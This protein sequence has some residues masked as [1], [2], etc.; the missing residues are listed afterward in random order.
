MKVIDHE[1]YLWFFFERNDSFF[2]DVNCNHSFAGYFF[3]IELLPEELTNYKSEGHNYL[4]K[5]ANDIQFT[6][7][8]VK[9]SKSTYKDRDVSSQYIEESLSAIKLWRKTFK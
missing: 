7:P 5:L 6:A 4:N 1:P 2:L 3:M 8:I 9:D